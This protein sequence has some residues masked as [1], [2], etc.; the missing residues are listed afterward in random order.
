MRHQ[1]GQT[2]NAN[3]YIR[4]QKCSYKYKVDLAEHIK[5]EVILLFLQCI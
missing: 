5:A 4:E 1:E 2:D 3:D